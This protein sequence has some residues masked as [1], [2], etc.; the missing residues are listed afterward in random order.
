MNKSLNNVWQYLR[1]FIFIYLCLYVGNF[2]ASLLPITIPGSIIGMLILFVLLA[3]QI[4]PAKWVKPGCSVLIRYMALLF[5][6]I[7][8]GVMQ[9]YDLLKAQYG[10][11]VV[12]CFIS[13]LVVFLVV[14]WSSHLVHGER[15][16]IGE[17]ES[18]K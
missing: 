12:S 6:P 10:P 18:K 8:V 2:L 11:I 17:K 5:V 9:Y 1:A 15:K 4:I 3:L 16:V 7:G 13:T 14:S